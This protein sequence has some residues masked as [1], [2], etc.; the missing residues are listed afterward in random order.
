[1]NEDEELSRL[2]KSL[3]EVDYE[4]LIKSLDEVDVG[5]LLRSIEEAE[6][7]LFRRF[8]LHDQSPKTPE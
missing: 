3:D 7:E 4:A 5:E 6:M 1:M 2:I 8:G